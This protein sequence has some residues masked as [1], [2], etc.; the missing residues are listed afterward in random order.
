MYSNMDAHFDEADWTF[1]PSSAS[2]WSEDSG[3]DDSSTPRG[4]QPKLPSLSASTKRP[5][6]QRRHSPEAMHLL[7]LVRQHTPIKVPVPPSLQAKGRR[8]SERAVFEQQPQ[9]WYDY[10]EFGILVDG[11]SSPAKSAGS[12]H[13]SASGPYAAV[14]KYASVHGSQLTAYNPPGTP[15]RPSLTPKTLTSLPPPLSLP[16]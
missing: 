11:R 3:S 12:R 10:N 15:P 6:L 8:L 14:S 7:S 4:L 2:S 5:R 16:I 13:S 9:A 1:V